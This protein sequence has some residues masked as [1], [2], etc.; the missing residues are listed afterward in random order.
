MDDALLNK[1]EDDLVNVLNAGD[2][3][4]AEN[5]K[6]ITIDTTNKSQKPSQDVK[7]FFNFLYKGSS[8]TRDYHYNVM[9]LAKVWVWIF[10]GVFSITAIFIC[11][12]CLILVLYHIDKLEFVLP[13]IIAGFVDILSAIMINVMNKLIKS[14][15]VY[16]SE[17][18]KSEHFS[19]I[20]AMIQLLES[21][22]NK[23]K[24][25]EKIV[26]DYCG[27]NK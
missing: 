19:K 16:F 17:N 15:D 6:D 10:V 9:N 23:A 27:N 18:N 25:I 24:M 5:K 13:V 11:V 3:F 12:M 1:H 26:D 7:N 4:Q 22:D 21:E 2:V 8:T 14:R 20:L